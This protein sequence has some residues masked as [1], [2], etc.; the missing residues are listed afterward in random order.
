M[1]ASALRQHM[2]L[3]RFIKVEERHTHTHS[4][5][6]RNTLNTTRRSEIFSFKFIF[7]FFRVHAVAV[8]VVD[9]S[10]F[11]SVSETRVVAAFRSL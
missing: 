1:E 2:K 8:F 6:A 9:R 4:P 11:F 7:I 10:A 3:G 5:H